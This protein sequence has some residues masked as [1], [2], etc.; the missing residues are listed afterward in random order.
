[1]AN[2]D[3]ILDDR[4]EVANTIQGYLRTYPSANDVE[5]TTFLQREG[6]A[7]SPALIHQVRWEVA[8]ERGESHREDD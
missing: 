7:A 8:A 4:Q 5:V 3:M 2:D 6:L 1:M